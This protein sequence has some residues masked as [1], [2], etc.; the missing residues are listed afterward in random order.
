MKTIL[1]RCIIVIAVLSSQALAQRT[2]APA[3]VPSAG[4]PGVGLPVQKS[5]KANTS[6]RASR[7]SVPPVVV[8][9]SST[10]TARVHQMSED[11]DVMT[12][13]IDRSLRD[14]DADNA[15]SKM[16]INLYV[17]GSSRSVRS[18]YVEDFG[19][20]FMVK[21]NFPLQGSP[22][23]KEQL[24]EKPVDSEWARARAE[25]LGHT[26]PG[27]SDMFGGATV[28]FDPKRVEGLK[29]VLVRALKNASNIRHLKSQEVATISVFGSAGR[30]EVSSNRSGDEPRPSS[31]A[32]RPRISAYASAGKVDAGQTLILSA[33]NAEQGTVLTLRV[34]KA[35]IDAFAKGEMDEEAFTK[36]VT[37][38]NY[39]G[40]GHD[41]TSINSWVNESF[42]R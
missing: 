38:N 3:A 11:L 22:A 40:V 33:S 35:D 15:P 21:V 26:D 28:D 23:P 34:K 41:V 37:F 29:S 32:T 10:D 16:G 17:T 9:F 4:N 8:Q 6:Y 7:S 25:V 42:R 27:W 13:L 5:T 1:T 31:S 36:T 20:L 30:I 24:A 18:M 19:A 2:V 39:I 12:H 14:D